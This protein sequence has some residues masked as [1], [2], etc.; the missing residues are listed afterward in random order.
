MTVEQLKKLKELG[1]YETPIHIPYKKDHLPV[2]I[3]PHYNYMKL[4]HL[5]EYESRSKRDKYEL[6][7]VGISISV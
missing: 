3:R 7:K 4:Y 5:V 1:F 6:Q 2:F